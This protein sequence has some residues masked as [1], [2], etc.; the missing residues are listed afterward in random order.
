MNAA[1]VHRFD[2]P[3]RIED[4]AVSRPGPGEVLVRIETSGPC[5]TDITLL[6]ATGP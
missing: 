6:T 3:L 2:Q 1:V 5:H 4:T